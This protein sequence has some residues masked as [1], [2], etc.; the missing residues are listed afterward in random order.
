MRGGAP[1]VGRRLAL[2]GAASLPTTS[3]DLI[4]RPAT[5]P[6]Q[7]LLPP[8]RAIGVGESANPTATA[9]FKAPVPTTAPVRRAELMVFSRVD[10]KCPV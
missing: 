1:P 3:A 5:R 2:G 6:G 9:I 4:A 10:G 7:P 8:R